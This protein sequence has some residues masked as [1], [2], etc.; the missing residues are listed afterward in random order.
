MEHQK[1][2]IVAIGELQ[3]AVDR[4]PRRTSD[5]HSVSKV[6]ISGGGFGVWIA[7]TCCVAMLTAMVIGSIFVISILGEHSRAIAD[8]NSYLQAI[9]VQAPQLQSKAKT[10]DDSNHPQPAPKAAEAKRD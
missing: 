6:E 8:L 10:D 9:Y 4:L 5:S 7:A 1:E 2:L 3:R